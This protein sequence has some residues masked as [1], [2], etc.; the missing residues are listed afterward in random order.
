MISDS[1]T[2]QI[3][4]A[5]KAHDEIRLS[6][7]R[8]LSSALNYEFIA[9]QH[10]LSEE[11]ELFVVRHQIKMRKDAIEALRQ[12]LRPRAQDRVAQ[13]IGRESDISERIKTEQAE[14]AVLEEYLPKQMSD[15]ELSKLVDEAI[16]QT[17]AKVISDM[18]KVIGAVM[19]K[20]E[21]QAEGARAS[22]LVKE[23]LTQ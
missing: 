11:E 2:K 8:M 1:I 12:V 19:A 7:L 6:T 3:G 9:K 21:G 10:K 15:E 14:M 5:L 20:A 13:G 16:A 23:K 22:Q 4:G 17:G 18:G